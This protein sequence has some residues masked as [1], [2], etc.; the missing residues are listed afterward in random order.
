M[1]APD[2]TENTLSFTAHQDSRAGNAYL[3]QSSVFYAIPD[4]IITPINV[5]LLSR[6]LASYPNQAATQFLING[7]QH[8]FDIGF[9]GLNQASQP[10]NLLSARNNPIA[11][12]RAILKEVTRGHTAGPFHYPPFINFH[13]SPLGAVPKPNS[14]VRLILDLS[15]PRYCSINDGI[16]QEDYSVTYSKFDD[17][18]NLIRNIG[19]SCFIFMAKVDIQHA[20]RLCPVRP[21]DWPLLGSAWNGRYFFELRLPFGSR[22][23]PFIFN[24]FA[25]ALWWILSTLFG[26]KSLIHYLDDFF[27]ANSS[28]ASCALDK[29]TILAVFEALGVPVSLDKL[30][31]PSQ[32][33]TYLGI[34]IDSRLGIIRLPEEKLKE[35]LSLLEKWLH[36][37][38]CTKREL[39]SLIGKLSF[40]CK[41]VKPGRMFLRRLIDLSTT[42]E[43]L[44]HHIYISAETKADI[45]WWYEF[46]NPWNGICVMQEEPVLA[47]E[48]QLFTDAALHVG[49]GAVFG[50]KWLS[51]EW[52]KNLLPLPIAQKELFAV[53]VAISTWR[54]Q[55]ANKQIKLSTDNTAVVEVWTIGS[56]KDPTMLKILRALFFLCAQSNINL[57]VSHIAGKKNV[58]ADL[59]SR[60]RFQEFFDAHP[61]AELSPTPVPEEV[62][63]I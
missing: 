62:W 35:L 13:C 46:L 14:S 25:D 45:A 8:G 38:K 30:V 51:G 24:T 17:A 60:A 57:T 27:L 4:S 41:V 21:Q 19:P 9:S 22:S 23:S 32:I 33:I 52:S 42:V 47:S 29:D 43:R 55:L 44:H 16:A 2:A 6:W 48:L 11:T 58:L 61:S 37:K 59:L 3:N 5:D 28:E 20:F 34:E 26:I 53:F 56:T 40:A 15:S 50:N 63:I 49:F 39:L 31:G 36:Q 10:N 1:F 12:E 18:I 54:N 7:F